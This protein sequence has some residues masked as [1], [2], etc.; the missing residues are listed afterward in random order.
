[1]RAFLHRLVLYKNL[2][3]P[4]QA[5]IAAL[6][7]AIATAG[8]LASM[9]LLG[10]SVPFLSF[11][12]VILI[13]A[14]LT[15]RVGAI[16][17]LAGGMALSAWYAPQLGSLSPVYSHALAA[18]LLG[19]FGG[20]IAYVALMLRG[21]L[22]DVQA[23]RDQEYVLLLE[24]QHRV[25]NSL[26]IVQTLAVQTFGKDGSP[27]AEKFI[28]RLVALGAVQNLISDTGWQ[29]VSIRTLAEKALRPFRP[30]RSERIIIGGEDLELGPEVAM[31]LGLAFHELA[32]NA[33]KY[34][35]L[36]DD[37][38]RIEL[39]W[40]LQG[41]DRTQALHVAW[42]EKGGPPVMKPD[43]RGFGSRLLERNF[44]G[45]GRAVTRLEFLPQGVTWSLDLALGSDDGALDPAPS[46]L[47]QPTSPSPQRV[48]R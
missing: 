37:V 43:R 45:A 6:A 29:S 30:A 25:K 31:N 38:G 21:A 33:I 22:R 11:F 48:P 1:M 23:R 46:L 41:S 40:A 34:G 24:I 4:V 2:S 28:D 35:A 16:V 13:V 5:G 44:G 3:A 7:L 8:R 10:G 19:V 47:Q 18:V 14:V 20:F 32:T 17:S 39:W 36:S 42:T 26:A 9:R 12:P 15:G 27:A